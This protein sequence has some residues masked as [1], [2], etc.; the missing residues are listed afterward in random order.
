MQAYIYIDQGIY[1]GKQTYVYLLVN[2]YEV[3]AYYYVNVCSDYTK[4]DQIYKSEIIISICYA[5]K[6]LFVGLLVIQISVSS[7]I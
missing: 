2:A 7:K 6:F 5:S 4:K 3:N 1:L